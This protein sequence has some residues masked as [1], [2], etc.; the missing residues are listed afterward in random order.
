MASQAE[1]QSAP[2]SLPPAG[3][4]SGALNTGGSGLLTDSLV[5]SPHLCS[6][7]REAPPV[8]GPITTLCPCALSSCSAPGTLKTSLL[9]LSLVLEAL[10]LCP[11]ST[12]PLWSHHWLHSSQRDLQALQLSAS[13][14]SLVYNVLLFPSSTLISTW[15]LSVDSSRLS[16]NIPC[17]KA[18]PD[19]VRLC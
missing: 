8:W 19:F 1:M 10:L 6:E 11:C 7:S 5:A 4:A 2:C 9:G 17:L 3:G 12:V 14:A 16:L 18:F 13:P 15:Y